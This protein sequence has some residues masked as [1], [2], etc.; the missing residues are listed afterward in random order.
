MGHGE[1]VQDSPGQPV[2]GTGPGLDP[3]LLCRPRGDVKV[4]PG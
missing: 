3:A 1:G 4:P 2:R